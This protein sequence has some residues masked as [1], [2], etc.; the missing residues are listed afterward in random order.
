V[1]NEDILVR[2]LETLNLHRD[3]SNLIGRKVFMALAVLA[4]L[5]VILVSYYPGNGGKRERREN[6]GSRSSEKRTLRGTG[7]K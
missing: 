1:A 2:E 3:F 4:N 5:L 7:G 6:A